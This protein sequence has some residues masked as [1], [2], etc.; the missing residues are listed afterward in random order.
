MQGIVHTR[1]HKALV[2]TIQAYLAEA[3]LEQREFA[4]RCKRDE[5]WASRVLNGHSG[6]QG[7][8]IPKIAKAVGT[9]LPQFARR[10]A[11]ILAT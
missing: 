2:A 5:K 7:A 8:D 1:A 10:W 9:I 11:A 4:R 3:G 6:I